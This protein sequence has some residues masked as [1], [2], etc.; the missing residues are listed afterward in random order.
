MSKVSGGSC[1]KP[2][3]VPIAKRS[4]AAVLP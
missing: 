4:D 3:P 1:E 2:P